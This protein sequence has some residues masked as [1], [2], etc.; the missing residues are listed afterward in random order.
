MD[1]G[2]YITIIAIFGLIYYWN[3]KNTKEKEIKRLEESNN[4]FTDEIKSLKLS[5]SE[6]EKIKVNFTIQ[7]SIYNKD[8]L[9]SYVKVTNFKKGFREYNVE[10]YSIKKE[11]EGKQLKG[12]EIFN[13][14]NGKEKIDE[15]TDFSIE[16]N[17]ETV[18]TFSNDDIA[19][20]LTEKQEIIID[21][22]NNTKSGYTEIYERLD[23]TVR[24][25]FQEKY[26]KNENLLER[27]QK[28][29]IA[30]Y[31][32]S[33]RLSKYENDVIIEEK[34]FEFDK[35]NLTFSKEPK[36]ITLF[37]YRKNGELKEKITSNLKDKTKEKKYFINA[38][39]ETEFR[40]AV[41]K[42]NKY[43]QLNKSD[44]NYLEIISKMAFLYNT[45]FKFEANEERILITAEK[46][47]RHNTVYN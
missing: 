4:N 6:K 47:T 7:D 14:K 21:S 12:E 19:P 8:N 46:I 24:I 44:F 32:S 20:T 41:E 36:F 37:S 10:E 16:G 29:N 9:I 17:K 28:S 40:K 38:S 1:I 30:Y 42:C 31:E 2:N 43:C 25:D 27:I 35:E 45:E 39:T 15:F 33:K 34:M 13:I 22:E 5:N 11:Y 18:L 3:E 26:D 23:K